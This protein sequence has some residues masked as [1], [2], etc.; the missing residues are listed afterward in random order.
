MT[1][2]LKFLCSAGV[3]NHVTFHN[4]NK[5]VKLIIFEHFFTTWYLYCFIESVVFLICRGVDPSSV[6]G[7]GGEALYIRGNT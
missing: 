3:Q 2:E 5:L 1:T 4:M 6:V 7:G